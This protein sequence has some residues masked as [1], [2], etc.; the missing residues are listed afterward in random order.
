MRAS[1][2]SSELL[3]WELA[4][5]QEASASAATEGLVDSDS[6]DDDHL[7]RFDG[8]ATDLPTLVA[9]LNTHTRFAL[10]A[11]AVQRQSHLIA[12]LVYFLHISAD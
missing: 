12:S 3:G 11:A 1:T 5:Q 7:D 10:L 4:W 8:T 9:S 2:E 6:G